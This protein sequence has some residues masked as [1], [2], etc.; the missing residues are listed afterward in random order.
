[1]ITLSQNDNNLFVD[2]FVVI[3]LRKFIPKNQNI[4][5]IMLRYI[6]RAIPFSPLLYIK[7]VSKTSFPDTK[8]ETILR[9]IKYTK[10]KLSIGIAIK[11]ALSRV[12]GLP[13]SIFSDSHSISS[14]NL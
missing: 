9:I 6:S 11:I 12:L 13:K 5:R 7:R 2:I 8:S 14:A 4:N 10:I 3:P 1:M